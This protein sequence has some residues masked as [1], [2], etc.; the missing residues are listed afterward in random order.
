[1]TWHRVLV[2]SD[3]IGIDFA[4]LTRRVDHI[5]GNPHGFAL[6]VDVECEEGATTNFRAYYF[7]PVAAKLCLPYLGQFSPLPCEKPAASSLRLCYGS[8]S[9]WDLLR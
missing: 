9:A 8:P 5:E 7:S 2:N 3:E 1:M 6:F 4:R